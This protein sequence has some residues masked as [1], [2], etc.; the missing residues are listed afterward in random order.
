MDPR[1]LYTR[2]LDQL[3]KVF[4]AVTP[5]DLDR[6]TPC[7]EFDLRALLGHVIGGIHRIAYIGEGGRALD[8]A[9]TVDRVDDGDW[10]G[11]LDRARTRWT[12]AWADDAELARIVEVPW[13]E[14]PGAIAL[15]GYVMEGVTHAWDAAQVVAP[16]LVLDE[17]LAEIA[18]GMAHQALPAERSREGIPFGPVR[19]VP[20]EAGAYLRLAGWLGRE[21][22]VAGR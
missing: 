9:P 5:A 10:G 16:E 7:T 8:L 11:A 15:G 6:P 4:A 22:A 14:M 2:T 17:E 21:T 12:A 18:L 19:E 1:P 3:E 13:G 20:A